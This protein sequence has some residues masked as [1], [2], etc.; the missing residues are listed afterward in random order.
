MGKSRAA[1]FLAVFLLLAGASARSEER[2]KIGLVLSGGG[3]KGIALVPVLKL[4]DEL[5]FSIDCIAGTSA[6][7]IMGGLYAAGY[8]GADIER[9]FEDI[10]WEDIFSDRPPRS[11]VPYFEKKLD[12]HYQIELQLRKGI[13]STPRG[14]IAGQKFSN[15]FSSLLFP[16]PGDLDFDDLRIPFRCLAVDII[17]AKQVVLEKGSLARALRATMAIPTIFAPVEWD[18]Y[19][20]V[21]GGLL[22]NLPVDV[23]EAMGAE[24]IIAVDLAGP[25]RSREE[26][27]TA[28]KILGQ[29][30]QAVEEER[31]KEKMEKVDLL[32]WPD[33]RGLSSTDYFSPDRM[34]RIKER[35]EEAARKARPA[36]QALKERYGLTRSSGKPS[37]PPM[38]EGQ[39][40]VL[41]HVVFAGNRNI[42]SSF[43]ARLFEL[44]TG[45]VVDAA[46]VT[47]QLDELY[48]LRY[49]ENIQYDL[50]PG[51][52]GQ[53]DLRLSLHE[54]PRGNL[55]VGL[56]YD[57]FH[58]LV[59]AAGLYATNFP[60]PG[61]RM[62]NEIEAAG[63]TRILSKV[64][65]PTETLNFP[66]Y[67][68][69]YVQYQDIPTR[70]YRG[71]G[72]LITTY[73]DRSFSAGGGLGF[74]LKKSLNL[75]LA[76]ELEEMNVKAPAELDPL[77]P[78]AA[79]Q[80]SLRKIELT[81]TLDTLDDRRDPERGL[82]FRGLYE[83][84]Y[85]SLGSELAYES[86]EASL[87]AYATLR[88]K[89]TF[90]LYGYYGAADG[91]VP[92]Y[93]FLNQGRPSSFAGMA[94]DELQG[95]ALKIL[96]GDVIFRY[97][98]LVQFKLIANAAFGLKQ[99]WPGVTYSPDTLWG[100]GAGVAVKTPLG[101][102]EFIY[103]LGSRGV[104][105][106]GAAQGVAYLVLGARF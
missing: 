64:S 95:T 44:K 38:E 58:K 100:L 11:L 106:P 52:E 63:L 35:G 40:R 47:R 1:V 90:R 75:E 80:P 15:L 77:E 27:S 93:K 88:G 105:D 48:A 50:F 82:L 51:E 3:A 60:I 45:D 66:V 96:R 104:G 102:M 13:P 32:I 34:A 101:L 91:E 57:N 83:G 74:L 94:F 46:R 42:P 41:G 97:T 20:L 81:A 98:N 5:D 71:D 6:G 56:R 29:S 54:L 43:I 39:K 37:E 49:F 30:L 18:E 33:M 17:T 53:L 70:L 78:P 86:A 65:F 59:A 7:G 23:A 28:E 89:Y 4:L 8:S 12:G 31:K 72:R 19:L 55:R 85:E 62:E 14:L 10:D 24:V 2:P 36:L 67:P 22:N 68:L 103:A 79:L 21:D 61:L 9:I 84:S 26:L 99:P 87:A 69:A 16:L 25:L 76:F 92:F 73:K